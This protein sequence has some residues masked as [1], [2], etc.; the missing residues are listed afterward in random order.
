M[1]KRIYTTSGSDARTLSAYIVGNNKSGWIVLAHIHIDYYEW[2][3]Y[4][5]AFHPKYGIVY[6]DFETNVFYSSEY[7]LEH[8]LENHPFEEWDYW[9]I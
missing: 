7:T 4:F 8:F 9:D 5:E 3:N 2:L 1:K 6:G